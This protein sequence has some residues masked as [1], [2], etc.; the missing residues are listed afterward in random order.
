ME[1]GQ[2]ESV[3]RIQVMMDEFRSIRQQFIRRVFS[4]M[5]IILG[6]I[7]G[8]IFAFNFITNFFGNEQHL[9]LIAEMI[10]MIH[11]YLIAMI[12]KSCQVCL[13]IW[14]FLFI[15]FLTFFLYLVWSNQT[16]WFIVEQC[17]HVHH[18]CDCTNLDHHSIIT[19]YAKD[20]RIFVDHVHVSNMGVCPSITNRIW[21]SFGVD[22]DWTL[23]T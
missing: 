16:V 14:L 7:F 12:V 9:L 2:D 17:H 8:S 18:R 22:A 1:N 21:R 15:F 10:T 19:N 20:V 3:R 5:A 11:C 6:V 13:Q 23:W 4:M